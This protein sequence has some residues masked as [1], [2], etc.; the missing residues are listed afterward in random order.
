MLCSRIG[1]PFILTSVLGTSSI[2]GLRRVPLPPHKI[3]IFILIIRFNKKHFIK[4][5][6]IF[7]MSLIYF[8][9]KIND[10]LF[11]LILKNSSI[12]YVSS[13]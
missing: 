7:I 12:I 10:N 8:G 2:C 13:F 1:L 9:I 6:K 5:Q 11:Y 3:Q 4:N